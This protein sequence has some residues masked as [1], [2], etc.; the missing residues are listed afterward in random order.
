M[1]AHAANHT[2]L[3]LTTAEPRIHG[4]AARSTNG[5]KPF[6][7]VFLMNKL[8][9]IQMMRLKLHAG[10]ALLVGG[11]V[12]VDSADHWGKKRPLV[13]ECNIKSRECTFV[14]PSVSFARIHSAI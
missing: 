13:V 7:Q 10:G 9:T 14:L 8:K 11:E 3:H 1:L 5:G 2:M 12:M 4:F 6:L